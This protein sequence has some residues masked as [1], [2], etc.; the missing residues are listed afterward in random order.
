M[1]S[2]FHHI[3]TIQLCIHTDTYENYVAWLLFSLLCMDLHLQNYSMWGQILRCYHH[4]QNDLSVSPNQNHC[5]KVYNLLSQE[6]ICG[7]MLLHE[8][9]H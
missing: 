7:Q 3:L 2:L 8:E 4:Y 9:A 1:C 6:Q 5:H